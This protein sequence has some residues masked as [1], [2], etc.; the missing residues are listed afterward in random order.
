[1]IT[2][3]TLRKILQ[4]ENDNKIKLSMLPE[5]FLQEVRE[6]LDKKEEM[7]KEKGD[8]WELQTAKQRFG[9]VM[10][11]RERKIMNLT[12]SFVRTGAAP[13]NMLPEEN[14]L[15]ESIVKR[16]KDFHER[17][18]NAMSGKRQAFK[19]IAFLQEIPQFVGID[20]G[21]YGPYAQGDIATVPEENAKVLVEKGA[22]EPVANE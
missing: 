19:T 2:Y 3:E 13:E 7:A 8:K 9:G 17:R 15:F 4:E 21:C 16:I 22:A 20:L 14:E 6:Y 1:M 18:D 12:L 5:R 11:L 10:E